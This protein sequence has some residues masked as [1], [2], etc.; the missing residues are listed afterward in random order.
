MISVIIGEA[1]R[2][3][4]RMSELDVNDM[5]QN[6]GQIQDALKENESQLSKI[7]NKMEEN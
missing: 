4:R 7:Q 5:K 1:T 3:I 6:F 2:I